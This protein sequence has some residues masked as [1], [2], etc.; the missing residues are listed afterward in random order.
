M[1]NYSKE[2]LK[3]YDHQN[4]LKNKTELLAN[5]KLR[6]LAQ[7]K[8]IDDYKASKGCAICG[9]KDP[10][11]LDLHHQDPNE[12]EFTIAQK[13][14][15]SWNRILKEMDKCVVLCANCHRKLHKPI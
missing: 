12:K 11:C 15:C 3:E 13:S 5:A 10:R 7:R 6:K 1:S 9:E 8:R 2:K 14:A 4:Y